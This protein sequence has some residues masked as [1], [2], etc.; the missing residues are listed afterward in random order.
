MISIWWM[1]AILLIFLCGIGII[2]CMGI[3]A[4]RIDELLRGDDSNEDEQC[5]V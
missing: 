1:I 2:V 4:E 5:D 3:A